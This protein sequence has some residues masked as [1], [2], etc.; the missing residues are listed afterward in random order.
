MATKVNPNRTEPTYYG[1]MP[2]EVRYSKE[3]SASE[4]V[5]YCE[6]AALSNKSGYAWASNDYFAELYD[7]FPSTVS[8]WIQNLSRHGFI[9]ISNPKGRARKIALTPILRRKPKVCQEPRQKA[10][11]QPTAIPDTNTTSS[12]T[13]TNDTY[14]DKNQ[15]FVL[16]SYLEEV[17]GKAL[18][19]RTN[20]NLAKY[21]SA[22]FIKKKGLVRTDKASA[23]ETINRWLKD[24]ASI[25][26]HTND[27]ERIKEAF[28]EAENMYINGRQVDWT[29]KTVADLLAKR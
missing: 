13:K 11:A 22:L 25:A 15:P 27:M 29:L 5:L 14:V 3:L 8:E 12:N 26:K 2:A 18:T 1:N 6:F 28:K 16:S 19:Q 10:E 20:E 23:D 21:F 9:K 24:G 7:V 4:K 17:M